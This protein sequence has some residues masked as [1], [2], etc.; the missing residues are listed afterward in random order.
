MPLDVTQYETDNITYD[1]FLP[2]MFY[3]N[4]TLYT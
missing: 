1:V 4:L 2:R 3:L